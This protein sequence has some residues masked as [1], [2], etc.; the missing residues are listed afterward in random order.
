MRYSFCRISSYFF[1]IH[2][3]SYIRNSDLLFLVTK[4]HRIGQ[5]CVHLSRFRE[6]EYPN[7]LT[8]TPQTTYSSGS[9]K[10]VELSETKN[11][12]QSQMKIDSN[13]FIF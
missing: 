12:S 13:K 1:N 11:R 10:S 4:S 2:T 3:F 8:L 6:V 5:W 7:V 9:S